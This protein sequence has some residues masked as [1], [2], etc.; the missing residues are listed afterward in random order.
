MSLWAHVLDIELRL[1]ELF[2][3]LCRPNA[4]DWKGKS[5]GA[6]SIWSTANSITRRFMNS[7]P[8][9][10][11]CYIWLGRDSV[12]Y[13]AQCRWHVVKWSVWTCEP[14]MWQQINPNKLNRNRC[15]C[16]VKVTP[17]KTYKTIDDVFIEPLFS[18]EFPALSIPTHS[19]WFF[20]CA[21]F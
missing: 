19:M 18:L 20:R 9:I 7:S 21:A 12:K 8:L 2:S 13:L 6:T 10:R 1:N 15:A 14:W 5:V 11:S 16:L 4:C 17:L 3:Y